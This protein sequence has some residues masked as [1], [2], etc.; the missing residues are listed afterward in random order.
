MAA[1]K[2]KESTIRTIK[3]AQTLLA[4]AEGDVEDALDK[5]PLP[6]LRDRCVSE[7]NRRVQ[8]Y[9]R[10]VRTVV[11]RLRQCFVAVNEELKSMNRTKDSLCRSLNTTRRHININ[12]QTVLVRQARPL[13]EKVSYSMIM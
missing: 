8:D 3:V 2:W 11:V 13:R 4:R 10:S 9:A 5:D 1:E 7:S 6:S 12:A